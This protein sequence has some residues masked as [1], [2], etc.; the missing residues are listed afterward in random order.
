MSSA[1]RS[2]T[3]GAETRHHGDIQ[4]IAGVWRRRNVRHP[5]LRLRIGKVHPDLRESARH[6]ADNRAAA[7]IEGDDL[8]DQRLVGVEVAPPHCFTQHDDG[9]G[10]GGF[11][12]WLERPTTK[13]ADAEH[14]KRRRGHL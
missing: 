5:E 9:I 13:R 12:L 6:D 14:R 3:P 1:A 2:D 7:P 4:A 10:P 11:R 8:A